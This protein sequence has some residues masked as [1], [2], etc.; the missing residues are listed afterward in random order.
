MS[1]QPLI[2]VSHVSKTFAGVKA[3]DDVDLEIRPGEIHCLAGENGCGKSTLIK[4]MAGVLAPDPGARIAIDGS[5]VTRPSPIQAMRA[6]IQ[7]IYQDFALFPNLT[8]EENIALPSEVTAGQKFVRR[9]HMRRL[10]RQA[11][12]R[13]GVDMDLGALVEDLSVADK[14]LV[15]I[16]RALTQNA[17]LIVMDEPTTALTEKEVRALLDIIR[18]LQGEGVST[19]FVSHKL[20]EVF[21]VSDRITVLRNGRKVMNA[22][23]SEMDLESLSFHMTGR[24]LRPSHFE[25]TAEDAGK[26]LMDVEGLS[27]RG[28]FE[29]VSFRLERGEILG[30]TG[31]LGSGRTALAMALFGLTHIDAGVIRIDG[32]PAKIGSVADA[33]AHGI[34]Y[35]PEDR[36][37]EGLFLEKSIGRNIAVSTLSRLSG[38]FGMLDRAR[39]EAHMAHWTKLLRIATPSHTMPVQSLSGG[40]QQRVVLARWLATDPRILVLNGPTVGVDIGSKGDIHELVQNLARDGIGVL[41]ISDDLP[42]LLQTCNRILIMKRGRIVD[43]MASAGVTEDQLAH[44]LAG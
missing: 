18:R 8:A 39:L 13:I 25:R 7:I 15:A 43:E 34:G 3:L 23:A 5:T 38:R 4:I 33:I 26:V 10:A 32:K 14:Q 11:L 2:S 35:V 20:A 1:D 28:Q 22:P 27:S 21:A 24:R 37:T 31:L 12:E 42:E 40:N 30:I 16:A 6:G 36:L 44:R 41:V 29:D 19:L 17:R 9:G